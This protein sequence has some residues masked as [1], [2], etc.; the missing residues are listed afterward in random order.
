MVIQRVAILRELESILN[1]RRKGMRSQPLQ[2]EQRPLIDWLLDVLRWD[3]VILSYDRL[4]ERNVI[5][6]FII[7]SATVNE[8]QAIFT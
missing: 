6:S 4:Q 3:I 8:F 1:L 7:F 2:M 5:P